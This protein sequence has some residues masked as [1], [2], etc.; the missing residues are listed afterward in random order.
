MTINQYADIILPLAVIGRFT[1]RIPETLSEKV[2][3]GAG[4]SVQFGSKNIYTGIVCSIHDKQPNL[5]NVREI[6]EV[7][8][9]IPVVN[10]N[11]LKLW[12]WISEYYLCGEGEVMKAAL[13]SEISQNNFRPRFETFIKLS[14][15]YNDTDLNTILDT[16][17]KAPRQQELL[18]AYLRITGYTFGSEISPV[19]KSLLLKESGSSP[20]A[21]ESLAAKGILSSVSF[22]VSRLDI[23]HSKKEAVKHLS[24]AQAE[25]FSSINEQFREK[26]IVLLHGITSSGKTEIYIHLIEEQLKLGKQVLYMLPEIALTTQIIMR[27]RRHFGEATGVYH[28]RFSD[29]E[30]AEIWKR[31]AEND[32]SRGYRLILGVRSSIFLPFTN[33][34]L[35]IVD[36]EH[37]GSYKQH[38]P[39]PRYHARDTAIMLAG[40]H[41]A[42]TI[43]GSASP[44]VESYNNA[45]HAK[46]PYRTRYLISFNLVRGSFRLRNL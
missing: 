32:P 7:L 39:A 2:I 6:I 11:Q 28:S 40:M 31:V 41:G 10:A 14:K 45:A 21:I 13:P 18:S 19:S 27:L 8:D 38:D 42:K 20:N 35:I 5:K 34:G 4:V 16:L 12:N 44:S 36:E 3:P 1:Y 37:D 24:D 33:L 15:S 43:L 46:R 29:P 26:D 9:S 30:K 22:A 23:T 25:A 17:E